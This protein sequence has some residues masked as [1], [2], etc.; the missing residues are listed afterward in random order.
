MTWAPCRDHYT[1]SEPRRSSD[2]PAAT[3][4]FDGVRRP[5]PRFA[6]EG[7]TVISVEFPHLIESPPHILL[8]ESWMFHF[9]VFVIIVAREED[10][11]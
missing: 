9:I 2:S 11:A 5:S 1:W 4:S 10:L 7:Y 6:A 8:S 3:C